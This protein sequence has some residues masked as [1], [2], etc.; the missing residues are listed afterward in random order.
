[1]AAPMSTEELE[2]LAIAAVALYNK[3][4]NTKKRKK[5]KVWT[6]DWLLNRNKHSEL[7]EEL[8]LQPEEWFNYL[9]MDQETYFKLL[10]IVTPFIKKEDTCMRMAI[11]P[12][13]RLTA[14]LRF[15]STG[16]TYEDLKFSVRISAQALGHIIP[17]TCGAIRKALQ[18]DYM[19]VSTILKLMNI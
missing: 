13:E 15:L 3:Q 12:H 6:K 18:M 11:S 1:M 9:R 17:E 5:R 7:L 8:R 19:K 4:K 16:R 2:N 10:S 14:T